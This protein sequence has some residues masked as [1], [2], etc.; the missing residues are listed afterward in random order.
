MSFMYNSPS[1]FYLT[2]EVVTSGKYQLSH[3]VTSGSIYLSDKSV[4]R[5]DGYTFLIGARNRGKERNFVQV[6]Y[7]YAGK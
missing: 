6:R 1:E 4:K 7:E 3:S 2:N 5:Y